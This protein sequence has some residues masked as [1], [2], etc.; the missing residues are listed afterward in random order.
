MVNISY[1]YDHLKNPV[2]EIVVRQIIP[3]FR[4]LVS[5]LSTN[6]C[7]VNCPELTDIIADFLRNFE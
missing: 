5:E 4:R 2:W 7:N 6:Q 3:V 1:F